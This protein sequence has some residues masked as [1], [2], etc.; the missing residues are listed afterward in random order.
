MSQPEETHILDAWSRNAR[1]WTSAVRQGRIESRRRITDRAIVEAVLSRAP[2]TVLDIGCGEGWLTRAL[3][4]HGVAVLGVDGTPELIEQARAAGGGEFRIA[5]YQAIAAGGLEACVDAAV[6]NFALLG[7][8]SVAGVLTA[9]PALLEPRGCV[10]VQTLHP[11]TA[12]GEL[13]YR[14]GWRQGSWA[15]CGPGFSAPAPWY[16]RTLAGWIGLLPACGLRLLELREPLDPETR[17]P[18]SVILIAAASGPACRIG[19]EGGE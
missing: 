6:C 12:C 2:R 13:P 16:F 7:K 8:D 18:A 14:D 4:A 9:L 1:P 15:G 11:W 3:A 19:T 5:S 17:R 10:I